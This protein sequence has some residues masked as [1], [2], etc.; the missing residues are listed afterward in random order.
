MFLRHLGSADATDKGAK[1]A[2]SV[3]KYSIKER[4]D[5]TVAT[6]AARC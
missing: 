1:H 4:R 2:P 5:W 6:S 3:E